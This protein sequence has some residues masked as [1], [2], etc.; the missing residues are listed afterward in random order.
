MVA[1]SA[2][3]KNGTPQ[4]KEV[5]A[6]RLPT[7]TLVSLPRL[8]SCLLF[9]FMGEWTCLYDNNVAKI[10]QEEKI[11]YYIV[12]LGPFLPEKLREQ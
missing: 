12:I 10:F 2:K 11:I 1:V 8:I 3:G 5:V 9:I 4:A 7:L 6:V